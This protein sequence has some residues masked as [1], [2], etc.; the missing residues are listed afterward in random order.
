MNHLR[1]L[2]VGEGFQ[3]LLGERCRDGLKAKD[4]RP[5]FGGQTFW[6]VI[7]LEGNMSLKSCKFLKAGQGRT[8]EAR[9]Q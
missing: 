1:A 5:S 6:A 9:N 2:V 3:P 7:V 8:G 4:G